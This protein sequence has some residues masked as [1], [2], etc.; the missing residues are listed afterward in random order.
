[1]NS[2]AELIGVTR[3]DIPDTRDDSE[4]SSKIL[5]E[6]QSN[7][8]EIIASK[9]SDK[10]FIN[11]LKANQAAEILGYFSSPKTIK[12]YIDD[13]HKSFTTS[14]TLSENDK[15]A[16]KFIRSLHP[17]QLKGVTRPIRVI[18]EKIQQTNPYV[19]PRPIPQ[20][21]LDKAK[22]VVGESGESGE[23][24]YSSPQ[25]SNRHTSPALPSH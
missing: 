3:L 18:A 20:S 1:M 16:V 23:S 15:I 4:P 10:T 7:I 8:K 21:V 14:P 19:A 9:L 22:S 13:L 6:L 11:T 12:D 25:P 24:G 17:T 2:L 5:S